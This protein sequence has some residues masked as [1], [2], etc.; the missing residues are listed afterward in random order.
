MKDNYPTLSQSEE[1]IAP[2]NQKD[3]EPIQVDCCVSYCLSK[4]MPIT[5]RNY[6]LINDENNF[7][8]TNFINEFTNDEKAFSLT[9]LLA[10]LHHLSEEKINRL[11]DELTMMYSP[12]S[13]SA[14]NKELAY[15]KAISKASQNWLIDDLDVIMETSLS[16]I[17]PLSSLPPIS[18][19]A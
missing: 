4:S 16:S 13:K 8:N 12:E 9:S 17:S 6:N 18:P 3:P 15:Y 5:I 2:W 11:H 7:D 14:V 1:H 19:K 10:E